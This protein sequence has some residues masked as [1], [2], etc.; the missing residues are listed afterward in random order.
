MIIS[1][2]IRIILLVIFIFF[3]KHYIN[4]NNT[5]INDRKKNFLRVED[6][7]IDR[8]IQDQELFDLVYCPELKYYNP[9]AYYE[10]L[11]YLQAF[12]EI[13][14]LIKIDPH[15][16]SDLYQSMEDNRKYIINSLISMSIRLPIEYNIKK[17][18]DMFDN[19]L[20][21]Y[22]LE[23]YNIHENYLR[24]NGFDCTTKLIFKNHPSGYNLDDNFIE[25]GKK[26]L[27]NRV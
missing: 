17:F 3:L 22:L 7:H 9:Q 11:D 6:E 24:D 13:F 15:R 5:Y 21:E 14:E 19:K 12:L 26:L 27:F 23:A 18:T 1:I 2:I 4:K 10:I 8:I 25:P 16:S 20:K